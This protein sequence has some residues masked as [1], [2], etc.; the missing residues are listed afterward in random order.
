MGVVHFSCEAG[1]SFD[2]VTLKEFLIGSSILIAF[3]QTHHRYGCNVA[4]A[5]KIIDA[6]AKRDASH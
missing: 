4:Q 3:A 2:H 1:P 6:K 5:L